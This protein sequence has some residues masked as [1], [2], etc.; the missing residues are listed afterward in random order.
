MKRGRKPRY[1]LIIDETVNNVVITTVYDFYGAGNLQDIISCIMDLA[2]EARLTTYATTIYIE[3]CNLNE[4]R[5]NKHITLK[6]ERK[7][8][9]WTITLLLYTEYSE[10]TVST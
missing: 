3:S 6:I 4:G 10:M 5:T 1:P 7:E 2:P 8:K 9:K